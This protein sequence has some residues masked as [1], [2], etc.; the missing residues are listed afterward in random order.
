MST[1]VYIEVNIA[2][3]YRNILKVFFTIAPTPPI[4][5]H[6]I[7]AML[8]N[9]KKPDLFVSNVVTEENIISKSDKK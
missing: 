4:A 5:K 7:I 9:L 8:I 1:N 3:R 2:D 6:A